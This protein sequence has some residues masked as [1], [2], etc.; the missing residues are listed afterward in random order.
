MVIASIALG[1][2]AIIICTL[3]LL[4]QVKNRNLGLTW[5]MSAL[6]SINIAFLINSIK[7]LFGT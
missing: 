6:I 7:E 4:E 5:L 2:F 3:S 1:F